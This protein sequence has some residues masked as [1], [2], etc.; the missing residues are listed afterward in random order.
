M[1][2]LSS[3]PRDISH[4]RNILFT[5]PLPLSLSRANHE[6]FWPLIDNI[7]VIRKTRDVGFRKRDAR[8]AHQRHV[9]ICRFK[10]ARAAPSASQ[11]KRASSSKRIVI[12][13]DVSFA[14]L[15]FP[16]HY[17]YHPFS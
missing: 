12:G 8:P 3:L 6:Q 1:D 4:V 10:R 5:L 17:E 13:C 15:A 16:D 7:Y 11:G 14:L 9:V 2:V